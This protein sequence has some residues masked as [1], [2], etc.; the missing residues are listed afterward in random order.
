MAH[1]VKQTD[2]N[3]GEELSGCL[4]GKPTRG[5]WVADATL[6]ALLW[7]ALAW[8]MGVPVMPPVLAETT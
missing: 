8:G 4:G 3:D 6:A 7:V 5:Q 1:P 2:W